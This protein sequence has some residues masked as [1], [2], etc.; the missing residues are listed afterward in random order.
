MKTGVFLTAVVAVGVAFAH[1]AWTGPVRWTPDSLFYEAQAREIAGASP[2]AAREAVFVQGPGRTLADPDHRFGDARWIAASSPFYQRRWVVPVAAAAARPLFGLRSLEI[3]SLLGYLLSGALV[4]VLARR[5][6]GLGPSLG[7]ALA[8]LWFPAFRVWSF[9]PLTD[10][11]GVA[12]LTACLIAG[13][14]ALRRPSRL[15]IALWMVAVA[16]LALT[17][18]AAAIP[19]LAM[20]AYAFAERTR[21]AAVTA[22]AGVVAA[23]PA[24]LLLGAPLRRTMAFTFS[25]NRVP[26]NDSWTFVSHRYATFAG[27]ML[28]S[29]FP[30]AADWPL[31]VLLLTAVVLLAVPRIPHRRPLAVL[32]LVAAAVAAPH[33]AG[34]LLV[35]A[36]VPLFA[37]THADDT[38]VRLGRMGAL[39]AAAY[40]FVLPEYTQLRLALVLLPFAALGVARAAAMWTDSHA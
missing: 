1:A 4:F 7:A 3:V 8:V 5:R 18:D 38:L 40:L 19:A 9:H 39:A 17:R 23:L 27:R 14:H 37:P 11:A 2:A 29:D 21:A 12:G 13:A 28:R 15:S 10:S 35:V 31:T 6:F 24:P 22:T 25:G 16:L 33:A 36:V 30:L 20:T 32:A 26:T 34:V